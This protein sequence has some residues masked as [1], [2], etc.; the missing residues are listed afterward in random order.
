[1][2]NKRTERA[3]GLVEMAL[4]LP[5]LL[6]L[7][8][9]IVEAGVALN[10]QLVVVNAAREGARFGAF[11]ADADDIHAQTLLAAS[12]MFEFTEENAVITVVQ[13]TTDG[14]GDGFVEWVET[15]YPPDAAASHV[16]QGEVLA[17]L[18]EEGDAANLKLVVV[19]V[20]YDH[21]SMLGLPI[22]GALA[23][24][25][26]IG[27]W[28][29]MRVASFH[30]NPGATG[31]CVLPVT[32]PVGDVE[33]LSVGEDLVDIRIG[34][35]SG[36]FGW[37]FWLPDDPGA[38][39]VPVLETNLSD[40]CKAKVFRDACDGSAGLDPGSWAWGDDGEMVGAEEEA[41]KLVG[42]YFPVPVW[43][44]FEACNVLHAQGKCPYCK[45]G[46]KVVHVVR[47]ALLEIVA[48]DLGGSPKTISARFRGWYEGCE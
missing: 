34:I 19:D 33:G 28:T 9:G 40:R 26:P 39:S 18:N 13:A 7:V 38:G 17:Q 48:V 24:R 6:V 44:E 14:G 31:C 43:D 25:I 45:P 4:I 46:S 42:G 22:V 10:K 21:R 32:L 5:F 3:Q 23:D 16:S 47:F 1:M 12:G 29:A 30:V 2:Q 15:L 20:R 8:V 36:Q 41:K 37:L 27:S 35:G 11:G